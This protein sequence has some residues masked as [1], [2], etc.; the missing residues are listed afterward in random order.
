MFFIFN[1]KF[2]GLFIHYFS[3]NQIIYFVDKESDR[4]II[5]VLNHLRE[6]QTG[7]IKSSNE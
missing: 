5:S 3:T 6:N 2:L 7:I 4:I 1:L